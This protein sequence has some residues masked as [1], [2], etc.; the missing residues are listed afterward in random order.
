MILTDH[1]LVFFFLMIW[2]NHFFLKVILIYISTNSFSLS[3]TIT[4]FYTFGNSHYNTCELISCFSLCAFMLKQ[5]GKLWTILKEMGI[6][7]DLTCLLRNLYA[8]QEATVRTGHGTKHWFKIGKRAH[9]SC[10]LSP[11]IFNIYRVYLM[12]NAGLD[13][14]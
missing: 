4:I 10:I 1:V 11:C 3:P 8:G 13:E 6:P 12:W 2:I 5:T 7:D 14:A 9:Q